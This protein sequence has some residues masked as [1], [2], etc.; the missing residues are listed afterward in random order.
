MFTSFLVVVNNN[1]FH[2]NKPDITTS[3]IGI[4]LQDIKLRWRN[5]MCKEK[6]SVDCILRNIWITITWGLDRV[7]VLFYSSKGWKC[8]NYYDYI[9]ITWGLD[10]VNVLFYYSKGW[11]CF[12]Y[13]DNSSSVR[14]ESALIIMITP[15]VLDFCWSL[16]SQTFLKGPSEE[17]TVYSL[18][19]TFFYKP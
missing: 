13:N 5:Y 17:G 7:N 10:R 2:L 12:N 3:R 16:Y 6:V 18:Q 1:K 15:P 9:T 4:N 19:R 14:F 11:K 8:F